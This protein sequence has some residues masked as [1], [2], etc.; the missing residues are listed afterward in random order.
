[1]IFPFSWAGEREEASEEEAGGGGGFNKNRGRGG[2]VIRG[3]GAGE[4]RRRGGGEWSMGRG[5]RLNIFFR[6]RTAHQADHFESLGCRGYSW[7]WP[8]FPFCN[9]PAKCSTAE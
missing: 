8:R 4:R 9:R 6:G 3:G 5:R 7:F 2:G 1:M